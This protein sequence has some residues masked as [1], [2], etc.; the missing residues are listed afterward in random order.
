MEGSIRE[1]VQ[2]IVRLACSGHSFIA[3][4]QGSEMVI[5]SQ[6]RQ[7]IPNG[8]KEYFFDREGCMSSG[9][10]SEG[11]TFR[12]VAINQRNAIRKYNLMRQ[13]NPYETL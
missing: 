1:N 7:Q 10:F 8:C 3:S 9:S 2:E 13:N 12:C 4:G 5:L 11:Y 6:E